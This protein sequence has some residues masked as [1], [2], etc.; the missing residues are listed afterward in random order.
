VKERES[1]QCFLLQAWLTKVMENGGQQ[2]IVGGGMT[3]VTEMH[4]HRNTLNSLSD[5]RRRE[6]N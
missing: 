4:D 5:I 6:N 2:I 3:F 1:G